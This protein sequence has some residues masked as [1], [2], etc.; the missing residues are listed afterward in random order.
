MSLQTSGAISMSQINAVL[1]KGNDLNSY[2]GFYGLP[3]GAISFSDFYGKSGTVTY[4]RTV[5]LTYS[6]RGWY[7]NAAD[8][9][10][11]YT[12]ST[13]STTYGYTVTNTADAIDA[14]ASNTEKAT[15]LS[16]YL[17]P[18]GTYSYDRFTWTN[19]NGAILSHTVV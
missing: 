14:A 3:T 9:G 17:G 6:V 18:E 13:G 5:N 4:W 12:T 19:G 10:T 11:T 15:F 16:I 1:Q 8:N 7:D 2:R